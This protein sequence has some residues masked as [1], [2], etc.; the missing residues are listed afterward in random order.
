MM[1]LC[2]I[3][4][5]EYQEDKQ[6]CKECG[7]KLEEV[8]PK[9]I[10]KNCQIEYPS[11]KEFCKECGESLTVSSVLDSSKKQIVTEEKI[12][13]EAEEKDEL[14][15]E[16]SNEIK[17]NY[18]KILISISGIA[19]IAIFV[20]YFVLFNKPEEK[21]ELI[22]YTYID[23]VTSETEQFSSYVY[24]EPITG[25]KFV[26]VTKGIFTQGDCPG[27]DPFR[28][29]RYEKTLETFWIGMYEVT[30]SNWMDVLPDWSKNYF[31]DNY[32]ITNMTW[33]E[34][35]VFI[36]ELNKL[37]GRKFRLPREAEWE[38]AARGEGKYFDYPNGRNDILCDEACFGRDE[39][40]SNECVDDKNRYKY[41]TVGSYQA[42]KYL[43]IYDMA[44]NVA[45][46]CEDI[47]AADGEHKVIRGGSYLLSKKE[48][49]VFWRGSLAVKHM[50]TGPG[51]VVG[52]RLV[53]DE[54]NLRSQIISGN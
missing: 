42:Q 44:G 16:S 23:P 37:T 38:Y 3:C 9:K 11:D 51:K 36:K 7:A 50:K 2:K 25:M 40:G 33:D 47:Y 28:F 53:L 14:L 34:I 15:K 24:T 6:F 54:P 27:S 48:C 4:G 17:N 12:I 13:S 43:P 20:A 19:V 8:S 52:F 22:P 21:I 32:P 30:H 46:I 10:C 1:K 35:H 39:T 29:G 41:E 26:E 49:S 5:I 18:K 45:E 31:R